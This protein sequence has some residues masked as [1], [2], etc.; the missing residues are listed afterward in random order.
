MENVFERLLWKP[1]L[2]YLEKVLGETFEDHLKNFK[3]LFQQQQTA[4]LKLKPGKVQP[5]P[6]PSTLTSDTYYL[7]EDGI[8]V[9]EDYLTLPN[10]S[11]N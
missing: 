7:P 11:R 9:E 10:V 5:V 8:S 6:E 4:S 2:V 1:C 3:Q